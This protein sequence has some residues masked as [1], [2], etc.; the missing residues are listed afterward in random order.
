MA[1]GSP[2][3]RLVNS[4]ANNSGGAQ[5]LEFGPIKIK[6][7]ERGVS[8]IAPPSEDVGKALATLSDSEKE[9]LISRLENGLNQV[10]LPGGFANPV[11]DTENNRIEQRFVELGLTHYVPRPRRPDD[12][13]DWC[14]FD[15]TRWAEFTPLGKS[16]RRYL[17]D[18]SI[19]ALTITKS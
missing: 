18:I 13:E 14:K 15:Q 3:A 7:S 8:A 9:L 17:I 5:E 11:G 19:K 4:I 2:L 10:C 12:S 16:V 1:F 6:L